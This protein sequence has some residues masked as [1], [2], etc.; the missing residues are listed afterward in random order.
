[1]ILFSIYQGQDETHDGTIC[2]LDMC[3]KG[4]ARAQVAIIFFL[5]LKISK[6]RVNKFSLVE[7]AD[8]IR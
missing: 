7:R 8:I 3:C 6:T 2:S 5:L 4:L 1:M